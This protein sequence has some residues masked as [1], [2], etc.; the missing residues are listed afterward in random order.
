MSVPIYASNVEGSGT[1]VGDSR[2]GREVEVPRSAR[3]SVVAAQGALI[4]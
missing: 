2:G 4:L 1:G 3:D